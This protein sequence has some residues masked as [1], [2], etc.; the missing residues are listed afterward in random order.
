MRLP[1][2]RKRL[3][4][5]GQESDRHAP[6]A[7]SECEDAGS[8]RRRS[9]RLP[10]TSSRVSIS[11][12]VKPTGPVAVDGNIPA[13]DGDEPRAGR[14]PLGAVGLSEIEKTLGG[15]LEMDVVLPQG[16]VGVDDQ[17]WGSSW[18]CSSCHGTQDSDHQ[19]SRTLRPRAQKKVSRG[20]PAAGVR[21]ECFDARP[22]MGPKLRLMH[23]LCREHLDSGDRARAPAARALSIRAA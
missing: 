2:Q 3:P 21:G 6:D 15:F 19:R 9:V 12:R 17:S 4:N 23:R 13:L 22:L 5:A 16:V 10:V 18:Q 11:D 20:R 1:Q 7:L 8:V 14:L